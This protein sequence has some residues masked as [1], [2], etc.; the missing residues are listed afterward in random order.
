MTKI[1]FYKLNNDFIPLGFVCA[2][3]KKAHYS[4]QK[5]LCQVPNQRIAESLD[6]LL[7]TKDTVSFIPHGVGSTNMPIAISTDPLPGDHYQLLINLCAE[8]PKW[9][10]RFERIIEI[11]NSD[12]KD[13]YSKRENF[14]FYKDRGYP[15]AFF[16]L[17]NG[18]VNH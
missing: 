11:V 13:Q 9:F 8:I 2:L 5:V 12:K 1:S 7:W 4:S 17:T 3:I 16:D 6:N 18:S 15:L 10:S 14:Q